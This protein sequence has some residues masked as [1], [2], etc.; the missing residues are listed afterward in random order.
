MLSKDLGGIQQSFL[1]Y[2]KIIKYAGHD[3]I[4]IIAKNS[5]IS[6][7]LT[8]A[9][10]LPNLS[11]YDAYSWLKLSQIIFKEKP[12]II[13]CHGRRANLFANI[14]CNLLTKKP[15]IISV[16]HNDRLTALQNS[17]YVFAITKASKEYLNESGIPEEIIFYLPNSIDADTFPIQTKTYSKKTRIG[18]IA[19]FV[20]KKGVHILLD[21]F[22]ILQD[23]RVEFEGI[24][25][26]SGQ[27]ET[28][29]RRQVTEYKL[30]NVKFIGWVN[31]KT[32]FFKNIDIF[33]VP[34]INEPFGI[35][36]L[37]AMMYKTPIVSTKTE[38]ALEILTDNK[39]ALL[40]D[41]YSSHNIADAICEYIDNPEIMKEFQQEAYSKA[42]AFYDVKTIAI[43]FN[44][45]LKI[46]LR[47]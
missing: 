22:K 32:N 27:D 42:F 8:Q 18:C 30:D 35:V 36:L 20:P 33:C 4:N 31:D 40:V 41:I 17:D 25:G 1:D 7:V 28:L 26:G 47:R 39:N 44:Q 43:R 12:D 46:I 11:V 2:G 34:S 38:G 3:V 29:L 10:T 13:I 6:K 37:E 24:I 16:A 45:I 21:A 15:I 14:A 5:D 9:Y 19:R 23:R